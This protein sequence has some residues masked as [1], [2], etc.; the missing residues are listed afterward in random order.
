[1]SIASADSNWFLHPITG[2]QCVI[3][4]RRDRTIIRLIVA[5]LGCRLLTSVSVV[6]R[7]DA[8]LV[9]DSL[10]DLSEWDFDRDGS[11]ELTGE[12]EFHW[13]QHLDSMDFLR[14]DAANPD[15]QYVSREC[16][17]AVIDGE[18]IGGSGFATYRVN[19][20]VSSREELA[21]KLP[22]FGTTYRVYIDADE[23]FSAGVAGKSQSTTRAGYK[24][25][26][27]Y[28]EPRGNRVEII[29]QITN[30]GP[31]RRST[32]QRFCSV[33]RDPHYRSLQCLSLRHATGE[34]VESL[35]GV[36]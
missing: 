20:L 21:I 25:G 28:F 17:S 3:H 15:Y 7:A 29:L 23:K 18:T 8:P 31:S 5:I 34:P 26:I 35:S 22:D 33:W 9:R 24:T 11:V 13:L 10:I 32:S 14:L 36:V 27:A 1:M 16:N 30:A 6:S 4:F 2:I 19:V 12:Y